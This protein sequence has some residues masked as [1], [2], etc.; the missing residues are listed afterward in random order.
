MCRRGVEGVIGVPR[1]WPE[2]LATVK[3]LHDWPITVDTC[4]QL[5]WD[6]PSA[7]LGFCPCARAHGVPEGLRTFCG[8]GYLACFACQLTL[9]ARL[10]AIPSVARGAR[11]H[12]AL[13]GRLRPR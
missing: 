3:T 12:N 11:V 5:L 7:S 13:R 2:L 1:D 9:G 8:Y 6:L 10:V 4:L